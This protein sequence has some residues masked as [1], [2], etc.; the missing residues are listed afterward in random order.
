[1]N[2]TPINDNNTDI[3]IVT[4]KNDTPHCIKHGAMNKVST[5]GNKSGY[6]RCISTISD[7]RDNLCRAG[8]IENR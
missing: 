6:W 2:I 8:C 1:M 4:I 3:S 5:F 7:T